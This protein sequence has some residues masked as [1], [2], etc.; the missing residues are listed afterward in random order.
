MEDRLAPVF[1]HVW[2]AEERIYTRG[3]PDPNYV[4]DPAS[5]AL[6]Q[7]AAKSTGGTVFTE[8][9]LGAIAHQAHRITGQGRPTARVDAYERLALGGWFALAATIPLAFLRWRRNA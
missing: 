4:A 1:V 5:A 7:G 6:L 3:R 9:Q 2:A 8:H